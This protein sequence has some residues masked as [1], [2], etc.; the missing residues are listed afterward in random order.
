MRVRD[1][2]EERFWCVNGRW[3]R[4]LGRA[5]PSR[6]RRRS[7]RGRTAREPDQAMASSEAEA[8]Q[9]DPTLKASRTLCGRTLGLR[10]PQLPRSAM[11][12]DR[13]IVKCLETMT[14]AL[15]PVIGRTSTKPPLSAVH[16]LRWAATVASSTPQQSL[17]A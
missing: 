16:R 9:A 14:Y 10:L 13:I 1:R 12:N 17:L 6:R 8:E 15:E 4:A 3:I 2:H 11:G 7:G 5:G